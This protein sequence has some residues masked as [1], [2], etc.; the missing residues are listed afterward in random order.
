M[1]SPENLLGYSFITKG[2]VGAGGEDLLCLSWVDVMISII[3]FSSRLN[4]GVFLSLLGQ[5]KSTNY[6]FFYVRG[7]YVLEIINSLSSLGRM[8]VSGSHCFIVLGHVLCV[9]CMFL[10]LSELAWFCG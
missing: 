5:V 6:C 2:K 1:P 4:S 9:C 10:L 8:W 7:E 3:S